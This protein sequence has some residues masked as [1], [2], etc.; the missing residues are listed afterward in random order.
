MQDNEL[1]PIDV[2]IKFEGQLSG[3]DQMLFPKGLVIFNF[4][5]S[6]AKNKNGSIFI[7]SLPL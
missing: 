5:R 3:F 7:Q 2:E 4:N 1:H 6:E